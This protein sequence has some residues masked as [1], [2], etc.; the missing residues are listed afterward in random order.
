MR[1]LVSA[2]VLLAAAGPALAQPAPTLR[3]DRG[4]LVQRLDPR[5][6]SPCPR[7]VFQHAQDRPDKAAQKL[8]ELPP[9]WRL[10]AV[11]RRVAGCAVYP[12]ARK[13]SDGAGRPAAPRPR[14]R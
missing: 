3:N 12:E 6:L 8:V 5:P 1:L 7:P 2:L 13:V 11:D 9:A 10:H 4:E 14:A